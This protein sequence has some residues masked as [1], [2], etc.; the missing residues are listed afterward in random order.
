MKYKAIFF[1]WDGTAVESRKAPAD[2]AIKR[3][4]PLLQSGTYMIIISGTTYEK[5]ADGHLQ[6]FFTEDEL[7]RLYLGLGRGALNYGFQNGKPILI[8]HNVP[9]KETLLNIHRAGYRLHEILL[10]EYDMNTDIV[11]SRP[12]YCKVDLMSEHDRGDR[13]FLQQSEIEQ[14]NTLLKEAGMQQ[15]LRDVLDLVE[16]IGK[17]EHI[18]LK[19]TTDAKYVEIGTTTKSDNVDFFIKELIGPAGIDAKEC[20]FWGDEFCY[21]ADGI[22][23]SDAYMITDLTKQSDFFDVSES[24]TGMPERVTHVGGGVS[25]FLKF[26]EV[27]R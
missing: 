6:E 19:A 20:C 14:V 16:N 24:T 15:G 18:N 8:H 9:E 25:R 26:L 5:I 22:P 21:L 7:D 3:M 4:K 10:R 12:N 27:S 2:D 1:D 11:Y 17:E 13:L 23:G